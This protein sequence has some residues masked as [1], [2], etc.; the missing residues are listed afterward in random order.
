MEKIFRAGDIVL[1]KLICGKSLLQIAS[2]LVIAC[3]FISMK[4]TK[5]TMNPA[6]LY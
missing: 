4:I 3:R 6:G 2:G 1:K 5:G